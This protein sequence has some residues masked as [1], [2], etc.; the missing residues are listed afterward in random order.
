[1]ETRLKNNM[2]VNFLFCTKASF[3]VCEH[4][5][6][7]QRTHKASSTS[8]NHSG[9]ICW[10]SENH[11]RNLFRAIETKNVAPFSGRFLSFSHLPIFW[12]HVGHSI[13][14]SL[15]KILDSFATNSKLLMKVQLS[16]RQFLDRIHAKKV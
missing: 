13:F 16:E 5:H 8:T 1:M 14:F 4:N 3:F 12:S 9:M 2:H 10:V 7:G 6:C 15:F 11:R